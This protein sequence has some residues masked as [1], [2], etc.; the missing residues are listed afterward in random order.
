MAK[1]SVSYGV[2]DLIG[3]RRKGDEKRPAPHQ[4]EAHSKLVKWYNEFSKRNGGI[5]VLPTG[6]GKT[7]V[8]ERFLCAKPLSDGYKVL[9]LA[10]THHLLE[11][12]YE[13]FENH[14]ALIAEPKSELK[15]RVISGAKYHFD[16]KDIKGDEDVVVATIQTIYRAERDGHPNFEEFISS[17]EGKLFVVLDE[18][19]HAPAPTYRKLLTNLRG[20]IKGFRLLGLTATPTYYD[21][22]KA[23]WLAKLFPQG[24]VF[25]K[26]PNELMAAGYLAKPVPE[27]HATDIEPEWDRREYE[28]WVRRNQDLPEAIIEILAKNQERNDF[29]IQTYLKDRGKYGKTLIFADRWFQC[30]YFSKKLSEAGVKTGAVYSQVEDVG[31]AEA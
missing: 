10:H 18:A 3:F 29:I 25:Q 31:A 2:Y 1:K 21:D 12:A 26:G 20:K 16:V 14:V 15:T 13:E 17:A 5:L 11:Q 9:W 23:G 22:K 7:F 27:Q 30:E 28:D 8:A 6:A 4:Q 19:H 24:I